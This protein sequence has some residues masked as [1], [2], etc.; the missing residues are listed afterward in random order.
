MNT[1]EHARRREGGGQEVETRQT[2][3]GIEAG[4]GCCAIDMV[5]DAGG[6]G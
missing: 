4:G 5:S 3:K 1:Q 6:R 2:N